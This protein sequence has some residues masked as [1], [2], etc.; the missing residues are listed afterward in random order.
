MKSCIFFPSLLEKVFMLL[1]LTF[2][3]EET[4]ESLGRENE[5]GGK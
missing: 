5:N 2:S 3:H 4:E 1:H